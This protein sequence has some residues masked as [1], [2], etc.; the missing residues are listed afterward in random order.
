F[1]PAKI[2]TKPGR[3]DPEEREII[4]THPLRGYEELCQRAELEFGQLMMV[5]QHH[6]RV[7]GTGYPVRVLKDEIHPWAKLLAVV[8]VFDAMTA[9]RP[10]RRPATPESVLDY[11]RQHADTHFDREVVECWISAMSKA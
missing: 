4:E 10:Y 5:Y 2:L 3:L 6:E 7:D 9:R 1:I 11:Q 8:D